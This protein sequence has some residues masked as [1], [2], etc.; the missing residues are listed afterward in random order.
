[1]KGNIME[2]ELVGETRDQNRLCLRWKIFVDIHLLME[3]TQEAETFSIQEE[4]SGTK[5]TKERRNG[6]HSLRGEARQEQRP[7]VLV[8]EKVENVDTKGMHVG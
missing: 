3:M 1:M 4:T 7:F 2:K 8:G 5:P 6:I